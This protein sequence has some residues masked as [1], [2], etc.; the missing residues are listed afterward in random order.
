M[1]KF[2]NIS[3]LPCPVLGAG[4]QNG[5]QKQEGEREGEEEHGRWT[6]WHRQRPRG[7]ER[8]QEMSQDA[9]PLEPVTLVAWA[10]Q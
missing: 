2:G 1:T 3:R 8:G 9:D 4:A 7:E 5:D 10:R 6:E